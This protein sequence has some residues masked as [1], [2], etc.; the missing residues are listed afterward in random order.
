MRV[1]PVLTLR[2]WDQLERNGIGPGSGDEHIWFGTLKAFVGG[3][4]MTRPFRN[5]PGF[6]GSLS[7]RNRDEA[8]VVDEIIAADAAGWNVAVHVTGDRGHS[9]AVDAFERAVAVNP[10]RTRRH[11]L[12]HA[13]YPSPRDIDRAGALS[14]FGDITP[15]HL[16]R[17]QPSIMQKLHPDQLD[18]A[19][20]WR[21]MI[22]AGWDLNIVSDWPGSFDGNHDAPVDPL[23]NIE[24]AVTRRDDRATEPF[25]AHQHLSVEEAI[26]AYTINPAKAARAER[27]M[28]SITHGKVADLTVISHDLFTIPASEIRDAQVEMTV[29]AGSIVHDLI[30]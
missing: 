3:F 11:R 2:T 13:W 5:N 27:R 12:V 10:P 29:F 18:S 4:Y 21:S 28:G 19:F 16:I 15:F 14:V 23:R 24:I 17:E 20:A 30:G 1:H 25:A 22:G 8:Q 7:F 26:S 6:A 9:L